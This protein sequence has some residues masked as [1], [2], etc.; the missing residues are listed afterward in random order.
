MAVFKC[1]MCGGTIEKIENGIGVCEFCS[2]KQ[3]ISHTDEE[4][5]MNLLDRA[6]HFRIQSD[7]DKAMAIYEQI[8]E[9]DTTDSDIYY[10][11]ALCKYGITYVDDLK[12]NKKIP[13]INRMQNKQFTKDPDYIMAIEKARV[14]FY[15]S[16]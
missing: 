15:C 13:T 6:N 10:S 16:L 5:K 4:K 1:K 7:F 8:L 2:T 9:E 14:L 12:T 3:T 11:L